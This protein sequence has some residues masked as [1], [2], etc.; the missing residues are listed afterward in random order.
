[1]SN[2]NWY[3]V[4]L[5][6][7]SLLILIVTIIVLL[8]I[9]GSS[10]KPAPMAAVPTSTPTSP[11]TATPSTASGVINNSNRL[12]TVSAVGE[13]QATPDIAYLNAG[14]EVQAATAQAALDKANTGADAI[15]KALLGAG[16]AEKDIKTSGIN[17]YP[18]N[19]AN[20]DLTFAT[21][22]SY[23]RAY[24]SLQVTIQDISQ[25]GKVLD[26]A[27]KAGANQIGGISYGLKDPAPRHIQALEQAI[28]Q[29]RPY[30]E[31]VAR[32]LGVPLGPVVTVVETPG[33]YYS[34]AAM[35]YGGKGDVT[36]SI[37]PG[38]LSISVQV[39]VSYALQPAASEAT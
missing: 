13:V 26:V 39:T 33:N 23:Y 24:L 34:P 37:M 29:S 38:Q 31:A 28:K 32:S 20:Q 8:S 18:V 16:I 17:V 9:M 7:G 30:A 6:V 14:V 3:R 4:S 11:A 1:M 12:I 19:P 21:T 25:A 15:A 2:K 35:G 36:T 5:G 22:P 27:A 10:E